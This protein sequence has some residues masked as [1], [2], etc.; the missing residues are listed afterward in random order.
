M[1]QLRKLLWSVLCFIQAQQLGTEMY[2][3]ASLPMSRQ[4]GTVARCS[5]TLETKKETQRSTMWWGSSAGMLANPAKAS[6]KEWPVRA[7]TS[8][9][10]AFPKHLSPQPSSQIWSL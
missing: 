3:A 4:R 9:R 8:P 2:V 6:P 7:H 1:Q 10:K 5:C